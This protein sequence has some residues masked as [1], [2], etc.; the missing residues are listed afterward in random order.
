MNNELSDRLSKIKENLNTGGAVS[1]T[2]N[3]SVKNSVRPQNKHLKPFKKGVSGNPKGKPVGQKNYATIRKEAIIQM[4]KKEGKT[5]EEIEI[6]L[7]KTAL[8]KAI[9]GDFRFYK[10]DLDRT[11]GQAV[12]RSE[13]GGLESESSIRLELGMQRILDKIYG[14]KLDEN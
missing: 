5:P 11:Y 7:V 9:N 13:I 1:A 6:D 12:S 14:E 2:T 4:G 10:D 8:D 3:N